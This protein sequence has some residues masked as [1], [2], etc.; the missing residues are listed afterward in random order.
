MERADGR[1]SRRWMLLLEVVDAAQAHAG[2]L[3]GCMHV[4]RVQSVQERRRLDRRTRSSRGGGVIVRRSRCGGE[5]LLLPWV[6][7]LLLLLGCDIACPVGT[8]LL[9]W[10]R[11]PSSPAQRALACTR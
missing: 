10:S 6:L 11:F 3:L 2:S 1:R 8:A 9:H 7:K 4:E 5:Q